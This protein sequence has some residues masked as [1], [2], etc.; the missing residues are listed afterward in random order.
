M[1]ESWSRERWE[2]PP[3]P[4]RGTDLWDLRGETMLTSAKPPYWHQNHPSLLEPLPWGRKVKNVNPE[5]WRSQ[6]WYGRDVSLT[7]FSSHIIPSLF[8]NTHTHTHT[9]W[10]AVPIC[11]Y[12]ITN[13]LNMQWIWNTVWLVSLLPYS[14]SPLRKD[15]WILAVVS[16]VLRRMENSKFISE[17]HNNIAIFSPLIERWWESACFWI[18]F[19][20]M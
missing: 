5:G 4:M 15:I 13:M 3:R 8:P 17:I 20:V 11:T 14:I 12:A 16:L 19:C 2:A 10:K 7:W 1:D 9:S 6:H 18:Y